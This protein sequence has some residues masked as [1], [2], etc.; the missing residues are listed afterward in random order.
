MGVVDLV[1]ASL[2]AFEDEADQADLLSHLCLAGHTTRLPGFVER[3]TAELKRRLSP[4]LA[5][6]LRVLPLERPAGGEEK[7]GG[8]GGGAIPEG[9]AISHEEDQDGDDDILPSP[10]AA[11]SATTAPAFD[12]AVAQAAAGAAGKALASAG[13][14]WDSAEWGDGRD[15]AELVA[16]VNFGDGL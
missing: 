13:A 15:V 11:F 14:W 9:Q 5:A 4:A 10:S 16:D 3:L 7:S 2:G 1:L 8:R 12:S 6:R